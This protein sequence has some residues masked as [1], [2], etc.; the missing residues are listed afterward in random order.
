M[1]NLIFIQNKAMHSPLTKEKMNLMF[2]INN[3]KYYKDS[4]GSLFSECL[5]QE[6]MV[7]G[8]G[9]RTEN[10]STRIEVINRFNK[11]KVL[12]YG[13]GRGD[14]VDFL[15]KN[16]INA[17]G[18]DPYSEKYNN[19]TE[20]KY[21]IITLIEVIEHTCSPFNEIDHIKSLLKMDGIVFIETSFSNW[22]SIGHPYLN[23]NIGH[24]SIFSHEGLDLL[25]KNK[26]FTPMNHINRNIRLF[27]LISD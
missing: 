24:S 18:Y 17:F 16:K 22:V 3:V 25:M 8:T 21:D 9:D 7:G 1:E 15:I 27:K 12:D 20:D 6:N 26:G 14:F 4:T 11:N 23:P 2:N 5:N 10:H 13:C 19:I